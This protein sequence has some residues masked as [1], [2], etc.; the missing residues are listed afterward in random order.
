MKLNKEFDVRW[1]ML[2]TQGANAESD[3]QILETIT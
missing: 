1:L 3:N 2:R